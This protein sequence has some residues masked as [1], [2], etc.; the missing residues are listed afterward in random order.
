M[1]KKELEEIKKELLKRKRELESRLKEFA[2]KTDGEYQA[3]FQDYG[4]RDDE[5]ADEVSAFSDRLSLGTNLDDSLKQVDYALEKIKQGT[6]GLCDICKKPIN[7]KRLRAFPA[8]TVCLE[9]LEK[10]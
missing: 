10:K 8:A 2:E 3:R 1:N 9:C 7:K 6:Y 4:T 5:M